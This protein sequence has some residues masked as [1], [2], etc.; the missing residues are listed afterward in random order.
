[1]TRVLSRPGSHPLVG[2][3]PVGECNSLAYTAIVLRACKISVRKGL[4]L[5]AS[6]EILDDGLPYFLLSGTRP[7]GLGRILDILKIERNATVEHIEVHIAVGAQELGLGLEP[8]LLGSI[9]VRNLVNVSDGIIGPEHEGVVVF[10][11]LG[12]CTVGRSTVAVA[13]LLVLKPVLVGIHYRGIS[14]IHNL[15][16]VLIDIGGRSCIEFIVNAVHCLTGQCGLAPNI[17]RSD[18]IGAYQIQGL[19]GRKG[20]CRRKY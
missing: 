19:A 6:R 3:S 1:M 16:V 18:L 9:H 15:P 8:C 2:L 4:L 10:V 5:N 11:H 13:D 20:D 12:E 7:V 17:G 14:F